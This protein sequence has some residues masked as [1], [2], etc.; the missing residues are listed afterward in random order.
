M[1]DEEDV[2]VDAFDSFFRG[3]Q[4]G[5]F[6]V[7]NDRDD[8]WQVLVMLTARKAVNLRKYA[9]RQKR[10]DGQVRGDSAFLSP[11]DERAGIDQVV[12]SE[13]TPEFAAQVQEEFHRLLDALGD[14]SLRHVAI[15]KMEGYQNAEIAKQLGVQGRTIQR[16]LNVIRVIWSDFEN[17]PE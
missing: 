17:L 1:A 11:D 7:L 5:R 4:Q 13:P 8:L 3:I 12:G 10:G 6:P 9:Q 14:K 16:K 2:V 15:A